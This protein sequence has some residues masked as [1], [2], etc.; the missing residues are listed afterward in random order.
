M[1]A[2]ASL[3]SLSSMI[4]GVSSVDVNA[5]TFADVNKNL[6]TQNQ[7]RYICIYAYI[8]MYTLIYIFTYLSIYI[9]V[10]IHICTYIYKYIYIYIYIYSLF[11][12]C[13]YAFSWLGRILHILWF[14][15]LLYNFIQVNIINKETHWP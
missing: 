14:H 9:H 5:E 15:I 7:Q 3:Q 2:S 13:T 12:S 4:T 11:H 10:Y 6:S 8:Y 1:A